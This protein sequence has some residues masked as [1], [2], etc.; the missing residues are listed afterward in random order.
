MLSVFIGQV[1][2]KSWTIAWGKYYNQVFIHCMHISLKF[3][4][5]ERQNNRAFAYNFCH[6]SYNLFPKRFL[7]G[8]CTTFS[9]FDASFMKILEDFHPQQYGKVCLKHLLF[10]TVFLP[11]R[12]SYSTIIIIAS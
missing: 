8:S 10:S 4:L 11:L 12:K 1:Y 6:A 5:F 2:L 3:M 7:N 9:F